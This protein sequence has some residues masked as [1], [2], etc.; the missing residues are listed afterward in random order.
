M[1]SC[2]AA[3]GCVQGVPEFAGQEQLA[4]LK[5]A[6]GSRR[7]HAKV[8]QCLLSENKQELLGPLLTFV[9]VCRHCCAD[10][11]NSL[12]YL[13][14]ATFPSSVDCKAWNKSFC[15]AVLVMLPEST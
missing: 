13:W 4:Q 7:S 11:T 8:L 6:M 5:R 2:L 12:H 10:I 1:S 15:G 3:V 14:L 9:R